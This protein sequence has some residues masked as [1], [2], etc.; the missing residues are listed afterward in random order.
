MPVQ[1][2]ALLGRSRF[3]I[4][5]LG[6]FGAPTPLLLERL[7]ME[8]MDQNEEIFVRYMN[9]GPFKKVVTNWTASE[10]YRRL[11]STASEGTGES[12]GTLSSLGIVD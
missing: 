3:V 12:T 8:G 10:A 6:A 7:F 11:R 5:V 9:D 2:W 4:P 1:D